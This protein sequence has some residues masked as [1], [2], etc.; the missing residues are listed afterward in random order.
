[1]TRFRLRVLSN[2][3]GKSFT[4]A[5]R[6]PKIGPELPPAPPKIEDQSVSNPDGDCDGDGAE[7]G[8]DT[9]DDNDLPGRRATR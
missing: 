1:M 6:S 9:D 3:L 7:N 4:S 8:V 5:G 2:R